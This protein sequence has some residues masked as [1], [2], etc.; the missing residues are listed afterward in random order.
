MLSG[1]KKKDYAA[2]AAAQALAAQAAAMGLSPED[3]T[4]TTTAAA[5]E[6]DAD[7]EGED[8]AEMGTEEEL[9]AA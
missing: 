8:D 6:T 9:V 3:G 7:D 2:D 1:K 5:F 4:F